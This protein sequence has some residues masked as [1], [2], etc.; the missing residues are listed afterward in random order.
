MWY[1]GELAAYLPSYYGQANPD[2][3]NF[4]VW[5]HFSQVVWKS[6][7]SIGCA[8]QFCKSGTLFPTVAGWFTVCNYGP[9]GTYPRYSK[10]EFKLTIAGNMGGGYGTNVLP[11]LG[12]TTVTV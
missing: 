4:E 2:F 7:T 5:G 12:H 6:T 1:N 11:P 8:T 10:A 3:S 9:A